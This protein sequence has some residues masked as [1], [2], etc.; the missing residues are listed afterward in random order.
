MTDDENDRT[1]EIRRDGDRYSSPDQGGS[2]GPE[3]RRGGRDDTAVFD[4]PAGGA[5]S[6]GPFAQGARPAPGPQ[7]PGRPPQQAGA[8]PPA[9]G[10]YR[11]PPQAQSYGAPMVP[12]DR[13]SGGFPAAIIAAVV[14]TLLA[15]ATSFGAYQI[16]KEHSSIDSRKVPGFV[17]YRMNML[18][19]P[20]GRGGDL[21][22]AFVVGALIVLVVTLLLMMASAMS[23]RAGNGGFALF[24]AAWM[25]TVLAGAIAEPVVGVIARQGSYPT[26]M[27]QN[28]ISNGVLW[29]VLFGWI[30]ALVLLIVH[31][32]RRKGGAGRVA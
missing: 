5:P 22:T 4:A 30:A 17:T 11:P 16:L 25:A 10:G 21:T 6:A 19:W 32:M 29:G 2:A 28:D 23:T 18:P 15:V 8:Y 27:W 26:G 9:G 13:G 20:S 1:Q 24:L 7:D 3:P 14:A 31:A 12:T